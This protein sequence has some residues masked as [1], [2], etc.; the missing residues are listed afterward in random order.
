MS[1]IDPIM[2]KGAV[3]FLRVV[4]LGG[5]SYALATL[6][7]WYLS[8]V[9]RHVYIVRLI[10]LMLFASFVG[11]VYVPWCAPPALA[12]SGP[13]HLHYNGPYKAWDSGTFYGMQTFWIWFLLAL[14]KW[15]RFRRDQSSAAPP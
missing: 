5:V 13:P 4:V 10:F 8:P 7:A 6:V 14:R 9:P 2:A 3:A 1:Q 12:W 11:F 15:P